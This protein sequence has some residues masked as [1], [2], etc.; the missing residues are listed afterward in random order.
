MNNYYCVIM[1]GGIGSRLWPLSRK[2]CPKQFVDV[3]GVGKTFIQL[4][5]ERFARFIPVENFFVV[6]CDDFKHLVLSQLPALPESQILTE[7]FRR[8]TAPCVAYAMYKLKSINPDAVAI[9]TPSDQYIGNEET[10]IS[11]LNECLRFAIKSDVLLTVGIKPSFPATGYGYLQTQ[12]NKVEGVSKVLR[13]KEKPDVV[14]ATGYLSEGDFYWNSGVFIWTVKSI[15]NALEVYLPEV[16]D[17]FNT[18][19]I[20]Y[21]SEKER[22]GIDLAYERSVSVSIDYGVMEKADNVFVFCSSDLAWSDVGSWGALCTLM[23]DNFD[24]NVLNERRV[25]CQDSQNTLV[26]ELNPEKLVVIDS[27]DG[28]I[29]A[30]TEDVLLICPYQN[31]DRI[32]SLIEHFSS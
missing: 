20:V 3:L 28:Y 29:V 8:N 23:N 1:A 22:E 7:P 16:A 11:I 21:N 4:T 32:K 26:K 17:L 9:V 18:S 14:T 27:L 13:F 31:E 30:D 15:T 2:E 6:T 5:Y 25:I 10:F 24:C 12:E 19:N